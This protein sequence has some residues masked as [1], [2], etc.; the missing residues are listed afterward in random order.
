MT[1]DSNSYFFSINLALYW[2]LILVSVS[3]WL[4]K[5]STYF[6]FVGS[7]RSQTCTNT[8]SPHTSIYMYEYEHGKSQNIYETYENPFCRR[9]QTENSRV[10][11]AIKPYFSRPWLIPAVIHRMIRDVADSPH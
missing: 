6:S 8:T 1:S 11:L 2:E 7:I 3:E 5:I 4:N 9:I 10:D